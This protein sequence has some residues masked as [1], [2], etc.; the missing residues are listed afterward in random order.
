MAFVKHWRFCP[1][2]GTRLETADDG[3]RR[4]LHC[5]A[6][7]RF[8]YSNPVP[9]VTAVLETEDGILLILRGKEPR[10]GWWALPGGFLDLDESPAEG[11]KR[12]FQEETGLSALET[13]LIGL[14]WQHSERFGAVIYAG[15][16][17]ERYE[18]EV[19]AGSDAADAR[20]FP[21][22]T[23]PSIAFQSLQSI[24][25]K[26]LALPRRLAIREP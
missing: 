13:S 22:D 1:L 24:L 25:E 9:C 8:F 15:Y 17:V 23:L 6:C 10:S 4:T 16:R 5:P 21:R 26:Y 7:D 2:C 20:F 14:S 3:E 12:E 19:T 18:G 11:A